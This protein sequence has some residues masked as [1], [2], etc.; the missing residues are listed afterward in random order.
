MFISWQEF[1]RRNDVSKLTLAEQKKKFLYENQL[2]AER[3]R[4][5]ETMYSAAGGAGGAAG[6]SGQ[7]IDGPIAG[8][9][10]QALDGNDNVIA[11]TMN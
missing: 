10:V 9:T 8:S 2:A 11:Q 6:G 5:F 4:Y 1:L 7:V 3:M